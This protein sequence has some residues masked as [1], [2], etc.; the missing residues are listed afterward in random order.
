MDERMRRQ[1][2]AVEAQ[3]LGWGGITTVAHATRLTYPTIAAGLAELD[4]PAEQR[5]AEA[6]R[7][8]RPGGGR[9]PLSQSDPQLLVRLESLI[10]PAT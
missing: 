9:H 4:V 6:C 3:S 8:R 10:E 5:R 2:A 1:W 7:I